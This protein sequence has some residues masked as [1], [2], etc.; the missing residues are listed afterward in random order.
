V[1]LRSGFRPGAGAADRYGWL[2]F[3]RRKSGRE[4]DP[5][6]DTSWGG[7][8]A[9]GLLAGVGRKA[10][11]PLLGDGTGPHAGAAANTRLRGLLPRHNL[12]LRPVAEL[13]ASAGQQGRPH[14][15][16]RGFSMLTGVAADADR[17]PVKMYMI[18]PG[19]DYE[20]V[21]TD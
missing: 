20:D 15:R 2:R 19:R 14:A 16:H 18:D 1:S 10:K 11:L 17:L 21:F 7:S 6:P 3:F 12:A 8:C 4:L 9:A 13:L 5:F